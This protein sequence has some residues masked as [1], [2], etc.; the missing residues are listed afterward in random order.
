MVEEREERKGIKIVID[1]FTGGSF[2]YEDGEIKGIRIFPA[3]KYSDCGART[4]S[5]VELNEAVQMWMNRSQTPKP[6]GGYLDKT[7]VLEDLSEYTMPAMVGLSIRVRRGEFDANPGI[8]QWQLEQYNL[9][10]DKALAEK[11]AEITRLNTDIAQL[12]NMNSR[13]K[14]I[15]IY[16]DEV[17]KK[18]IARLKEY[19]DVHTTRIIELEDRIADLEKLST[20]QK[21]TIDAQGKE[22][23]EA[24]EARETVLNDVWIKCF[25]EMNFQSENRIHYDPEDSYIPSLECEEIVNILESLGLN[26]PAPKEPELFICPEAGRSARLCPLCRHSRPHECDGQRC[27][28]GVCIP[29]EEPAQ[30]PAVPEEEKSPI[31]HLQDRVLELEQ[32]QGRDRADLMEKIRV[33][34]K[35]HETIRGS[36]DFQWQKQK[37]RIAGLEHRLGLAQD[38]IAEIHPGG[39]V[40]PAKQKPGRPKKKVN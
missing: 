14:E 36:M 24:R 4:L 3:C 12:K 11:D 19:Q 17:T 2:R 8:S 1:E 32:H 39:C 31:Q 22:L 23:R 25:N 6:I 38:R 27:C 37:D 33:L 34:E 18:K 30:T 35:S 28:K 26:K 40:P 21:A 9:A 5:P 7:K 10:H 29:Y 20:M 15:P 13:L 16:V